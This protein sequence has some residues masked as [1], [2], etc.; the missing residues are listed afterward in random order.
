MTNIKD[1]VKKAKAFAVDVGAS[2]G[3]SPARVEEVLH[4]RVDESLDEP[5][6]VWRITLGWPETSYKETGGN[7]GI[8]ASIGVVDNVTLEALPRYYKVFDVDILSG[9]VISMTMK[10]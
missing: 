7:K 1:A 2:K 8:L 6:E 10:Y 5:S 9:E 4:V 3:N